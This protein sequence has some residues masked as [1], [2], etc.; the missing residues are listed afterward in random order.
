MSKLHPLI[1]YYGEITSTLDRGKELAAEGKFDAWDSLVAVSQSAGRGQ[2]RRAWHSPAGNL[3]AAIRLPLSPPFNSQAAAIAA[4]FLCAS[5]LI[6]QGYSVFLKWPNDLVMFNKGSP[7]K[8]GGILLEEQKGALIAGIGI[9]ITAPPESG[10][11]RES[12]AIAPGS[13]GRAPAPSSL[14]PL[15]VKG[16]LRAY[17]NSAFFASEWRLL[18][19]SVLL[20]RNEE[21][22]IADNGYVRRGIFRGLAHDG[23]ALIENSGTVTACSCGSMRRTD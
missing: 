12:A 8:V 13:L 6:G 7:V 4:G 16:M 9:N 2:M 23:A 20:W 11:M 17:K 21:A 22:E 15:I 5:A 19:E 14:W 1:H 18:A 10:F 3:Y